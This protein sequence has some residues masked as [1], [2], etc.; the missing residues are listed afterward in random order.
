MLTALMQTL[1]KCDMGSYEYVVVHSKIG[2]WHLQDALV[3]VIGYFM[4]Q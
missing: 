4:L 3:N 1:C 2:R